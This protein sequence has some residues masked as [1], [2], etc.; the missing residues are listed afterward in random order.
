MKLFARLGALGRHI[1]GW[2]PIGSAT[3]AGALPLNTRRRVFISTAGA[4]F[5][6]V[7][8]ILIPL[9]IPW[10]YVI[11]GP[12]AQFLCPPKAP[13][14]HFALEVSLTAPVFLMVL[15][16]VLVGL[17]VHFRSE[18][19]RRSI[20]ITAAA[21]GIFSALVGASFLS[22]VPNIPPYIDICNST[23]CIPSTTP[24]TPFFLIVFG[25][26]IIMFGVLYRRGQGVS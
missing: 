14:L 15:G 23:V 18:R 6:A 25:A 8:A 10:Y 11:D 26:G 12:L 2:L 22:Y 21:G 19:H 17:G 4:F 13:C 20:K 5:V 16:E 3:M 1:R 9:V 24:I 7:G